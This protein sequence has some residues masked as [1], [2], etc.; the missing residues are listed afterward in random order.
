M[1]KKSQNLPFGLALAHILLDKGLSQQDL[2][3][4]LGTAEGLVSNV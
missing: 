2:E 3:R 4:L 1:P